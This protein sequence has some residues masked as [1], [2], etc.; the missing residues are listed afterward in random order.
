[1]AASVQQFLFL[2][3]QQSHPCKVADPLVED[4]YRGYKLVADETG[5]ESQE[6]Y[7][8]VKI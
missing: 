5:S 2:R 8:E 3:T 4:R 6:L 1:M 7:D